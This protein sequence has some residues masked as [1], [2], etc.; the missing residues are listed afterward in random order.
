MGRAGFRGRILGRAPDGQARNQQGWLANAR[1]DALS[2][3][4][5]Y[6]NAFV[7]RH[8]IADAHDLGQHAGSVADQGCALDWIADFAIVNRLGFGAAKDEFAGYNVH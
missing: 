5:A 4:A 2:A 7:N 3:L 1:R 8:I 6:A